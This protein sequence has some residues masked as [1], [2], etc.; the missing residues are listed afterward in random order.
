M[1][2]TCGKKRRANNEKSDINGSTD[3]S[4]QWLC[5]DLHGNTNA[6]RWLV[7]PAVELR[8]AAREAGVPAP[9]IAVLTSLG[10]GDAGALRERVHAFREAGATRIIHAA[11]YD[12]AEEFRAQAYTLGAIKGA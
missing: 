5:V 11:R 10:S 4:T 9:Q 2:S 1:A 6:D 3:Y 12:T 8:R 7:A